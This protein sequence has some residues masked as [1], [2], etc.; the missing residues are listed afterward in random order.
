MGHANVR[1]PMKTKIAMLRVV[2]AL[3]FAGG[4]KRFVVSVSLVAYSPLLA[5][6]VV[7][8]VYLFA[9]WRINRTIF[10]SLVVEPYHGAATIGGTIKA[11]WKLIRGWWFRWPIFLVQL[12]LVMAN[13]I[14]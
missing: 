7:P 9:G 2:A 3:L 14:R 1:Q 6:F 13:G 8:K 4:I 10:D 11:K 12:W 5:L